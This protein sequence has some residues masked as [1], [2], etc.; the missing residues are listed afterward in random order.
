MRLRFIGAD[1]TM[2][3]YNNKTYEVSVKSYEYGIIL[4]V[5]IE[6][7]EGIVFGY[8]SPQALA[9]DWSL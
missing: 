9:N 5:K 4:I 6:S 8:S 1:G 2:G 7:L 3:L